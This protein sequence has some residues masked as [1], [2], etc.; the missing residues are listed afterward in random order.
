[1]DRDD[2]RDDMIDVLIEK[3]VYI[4]QQTSIPQV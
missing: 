1:M 3:N 2:D 4:R